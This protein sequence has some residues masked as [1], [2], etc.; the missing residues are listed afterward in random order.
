MKHEVGSIHTAETRASYVRSSAAVSLY[1]LLAGWLAN[2]T[3]FL[4]GAA[5][6]R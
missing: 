3:N 4:G 6:R 1:L 2:P 5:A